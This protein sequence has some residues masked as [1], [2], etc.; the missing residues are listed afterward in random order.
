MFIAT[1]LD[2]WQMQQAD[3]DPSVVYSVNHQYTPHVAVMG[4]MNESGSGKMVRIRRIEVTPQSVSIGL[5]PTAGARVY[6]SLQLVLLTSVSS[7]EALPAIKAD[8]TMAAPPA[9]VVGY[10]YPGGYGVTGILYKTFISFSWAQSRFFVD[11]NGQGRNTLGAFFNPWGAAVQK[12]VLAEGEGIG[13]YTPDEW[14]PSKWSVEAVVT[15]GVNQWTYAT[16]I[17]T[18]SQRMAFAVAN[19]VGSGAVLQVL[20]LTV[21]P[22]GP[23]QTSEITIEGIAAMRNPSGTTITPV[24]TDTNEVLP[25]GITIK[26][27]PLCIMQTSDVGGVV[28][29]PRRRALGLAGP[30]YIDTCLS[31]L[32][33]WHYP[34]FDSVGQTLDMVLR[35]GSGVAIFSHVPS[36]VLDY[37]FS[38]QFTVE[39]DSGGAGGYVYVK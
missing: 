36:G 5:P 23:G 1:S 4:I 33:C 26:A 16:T 12:I 37:G 14:G 20:K 27:N 34:T 38:I 31:M 28:Q 35:E 15:D 3:E 19:Q 11:W 25:A 24:S 2:D 13:L 29:A 39:P 30:A 9:G 10:R 18:S 21:A 22:A 32:G 17:T 6:A 8:S 7:G